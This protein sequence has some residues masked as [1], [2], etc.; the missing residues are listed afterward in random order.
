MQPAIAFALAGQ[1]KTFIILAR[2]LKHKHLSVIAAAFW[3]LLRF[4]SMVTSIFLCLY[5]LG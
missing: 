5:N 2:I 3:V 1:K 4:A